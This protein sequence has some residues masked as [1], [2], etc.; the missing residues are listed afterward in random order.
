MTQKIIQVPKE[1]PKFS[2]LQNKCH[3]QMTHEKDDTVGSQWGA[4]LEASWFREVCIEDFD[5]LLCTIIY[6]H[7][8]S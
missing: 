2:S 1:I 3:F 4:N 5:E 7:V 6:Y 8:L